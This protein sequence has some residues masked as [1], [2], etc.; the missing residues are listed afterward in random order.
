MWTPAFVLRRAAFIAGSY[1]RKAKRDLRYNLTDSF[2]LCGLIERAGTVP[3]SG[4]THRRDA[5]GTVVDDAKAAFCRAHAVAHPQVWEDE[6][7]PRPHQ[8][9]EALLTA[10]RLIS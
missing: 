9:R 1:D 3:K 4:A 6:T 2:H 7:R 5:G 10:A 8:V